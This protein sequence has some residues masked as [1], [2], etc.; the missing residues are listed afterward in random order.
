M[1]DLRSE[2][3]TRLKILIN[4]LNING[5]SF[6]KALGISQSMASNMLNGNRAITIE[7]VDKISE[8]YKNINPAWLLFG[9]GDI[10]NDNDESRN[11]VIKEDKAIYSPEPKIKLPEKVTAGQ[12]IA[13]I[14]RRLGMSQDKFAVTLGATRAQVSNWERGKTALPADVIIQ[15]S[16][17]TGIS[18]ERLH[19]TDLPS[20][21]IRT[22]Q[23]ESG[24]DDKLDDIIK[25]LK[26]INEKLGDLKTEIFYF[27]PRN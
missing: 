7:M 14:R 19:T 15:I 16:K 17:I 20:K 27:M 23:S 26:A 4:Y 21:N 11:Y 24:Q 18:A 25:E 12:N 22:L 6:A 10:E 9:T 13:A 2:R 3:A 1:D 8:R 5:I